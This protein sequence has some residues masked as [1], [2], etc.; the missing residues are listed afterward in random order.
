VPPDAAGLGDAIGAGLADAGRVVVPA[1]VSDDLVRRLRERARS[2]DRDARFAPARVGRAGSRT[3][4]ADIRGDR[5]AWLDATTTDAAER[6]LAAALDG[7]RLAANRALALGAFDGEFHFAIYPPG[8]GY[9]RHRDRFRDDDA[10]V[11]SCIV[12]LNL[13]WR[14]GDGGH[15]RFHDDGGAS[16][17]VRPDGGTLVAFLA[18]RHEH[19]VLPATRER[20][21]VSGWFRQRG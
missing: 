10:R 17:D 2:L 19:E 5:I 20:M 11:L 15:L 3:E 12:Y 14:D 7:V 13:D 4:R 9:A 1:F 6:E 18:D 16:M 21:T 8:A